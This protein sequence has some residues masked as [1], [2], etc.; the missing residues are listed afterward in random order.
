[1]SNEPRLFQCEGFNLVFVL[2]E[3]SFLFEKG[4]WKKI[5]ATISG[6]WETFSQELVKKLLKCGYLPKRSSNGIELPELDLIGES[7]LNNLANKQ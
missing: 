7:T 5:P 1:M 4:E 3:Q 6:I 2:G